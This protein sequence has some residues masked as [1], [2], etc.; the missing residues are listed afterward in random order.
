MFQLKYYAELLWETMYTFPFLSSSLAVIGAIYLVVSL[1]FVFGN[2]VYLVQLVDQAA[3]TLPLL[4]IAFFE[5]IA[6][7]WVYGTR[8][9]VCVCVCV[10]ACVCVYS[11]CSICYTVHY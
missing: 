5:V 11:A 8:R 10:R 4:F 3:S 1:V 6:I 9:S 2:G 7:A